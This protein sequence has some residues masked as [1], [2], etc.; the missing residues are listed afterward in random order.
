MDLLLLLLINRFV[1]TLCINE[2]KDCH[3]LLKDDEEKNVNDKLSIYL[4][5]ASIKWIKIM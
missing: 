3:R 2:K 5:F 1:Q 4:S